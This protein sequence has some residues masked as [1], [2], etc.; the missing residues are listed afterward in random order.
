MKSTKSRSI[1]SVIVLILPV[2]LNAQ[3]Q[4]SNYKTLIQRI[5]AMAK[6]YPDLCKASAIGKT[7]G[8][9]DIMVL[10]IGTGE[11]DN[12][13]GIAL[14]A[15]T[16]GSYI[17][18]RE[19]ALGF[20]GSLLRDASSPEIKTL[21][22]K[23]T[24]YIFP[25]VN[26]DATEQ[27][28]Q[29]IRY[30]RSTNARPV[31]EDRDFSTDED[32]FE[33]INGDGVIT[34]LRVSDSSGA[35]TE[36]SEDKRIMVPAD[37]SK[38]EKGTYSIYTEGIDN[39][40][41]GKFNE[42]GPGGISFN[43]NMTYNYEEFGANAGLHPV[44]EPESKAVMDFL[45]GHYNIYATLSF[46][47]QDNLTQA[48]RGGGDR[49]AQGQA[50]Q[51]ASQP[52]PGA[53]QTGRMGE[54]RISSVMRSDE[55]VIRLVGEKYREITGVKGSPQTKSDPGNFADWS[56]FHYGRYSFST[57]AWWYPVE[58]DKNAEA[59]FLKFAEENKLGDVF[60]PWT[61]I[62]H[63]DFPGKKT[64]VGG[65]KPF[66]MINPPTEKIEEL[67]ASNYKFITVVAAMHPELELIDV[68]TENKGEKIY[69]L[70]LKVH[71]KGLFA[72][73]TEAGQN[74]IFTRLMRLSIETDKGL[75]IL[76]GQKVQRIPRL[77][78]NKT[79]EYSWLLMG[80]GNVTVTAGAVNTGFASSTI[81]LK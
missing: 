37:L 80:K 34:L 60:V 54:R 75:T 32:P 72:T 40:K 14:A 62:E 29:N 73:C 16:D 41:D 74:N 66:L 58:R 44:S 36:S 42:D 78:G 3:V 55:T 13:P 63:P 30:E 10:T 4:Y 71:N 77:E 1:L 65:I 67:V 68:E 20:A 25:D 18:G 79:A 51:A 53:G 11:R 47:P 22:E 5:D 56:Y 28:F 49:G 35:Y 19:L 45:F 76:S 23:V 31:D 70:T 21:L 38:G 64:E 2:F 9:K 33:D 46:G 61:V 15:C 43:R 12:K 81:V 26:P 17:L 6:Q 52:G 50:Q 48:S 8:G 39:D 7:E 57:P 69:R 59:A 27:Y 24:F